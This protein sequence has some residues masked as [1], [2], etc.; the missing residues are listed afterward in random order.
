[1]AKSYELD[2]PVAR[3]L[4][5]VGEKWTLLILRDLFTKGPQR[6]LDFEKSLES[7]PPSTLSAR[8][9]TLEEA[10]II[11]AELYDTHPPRSRYALTDKGRKLGP[12]LLAL[13]QWGTDYT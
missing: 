4:D 10:G 9:K 3:T 5:I 12:V 13:R 2:C 1:M 7:V 8:I 6:F 11:V